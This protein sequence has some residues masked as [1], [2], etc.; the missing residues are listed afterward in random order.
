MDF[1]H[2][3]S[4]PASVC[5]ESLVHL[6]DGATVR[7]RAA[8][9]DGHDDDAFRR[10]FFTL[11]DTTRYLYFCAGVPSNETW[12]E[13]FVALGHADDCLS[14]VLVAEVDDDLIGFARLGRSPRT[15]PHTMEVGI[16]LTD[17]WQR[18]GLGGQMLRRLAVEARRHAIQAFTALALSENRRVLRLARR[19]FP[20]VHIAC[21]AGSC[22]LTLDLEPVSEV[23]L[24]AEP[25][26]CKVCLA[27]GVCDGSFDGNADQ[28]WPIVIHWQRAESLIST[29]F[30][31]V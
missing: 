27:P 7:L 28:P 12:A 17:A 23:E 4:D 1:L 26:E 18:R 2:D 20:G 5:D 15:D 10:L 16:I 30:A 21:A 9:H 25:R 11:S 14:F 19:T 13:R 22:E 6:A 3:S 31:D 29:G 24:T 8:S